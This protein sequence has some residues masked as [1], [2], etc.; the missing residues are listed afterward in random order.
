MFNNMFA[1]VCKVKIGAKLE[2]D[3]HD[4]EQPTIGVSQHNYLSP[5]KS[6][7]YPRYYLEIFI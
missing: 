6:R 7:Q 4:Q 1:S 2:Y 3:D 5:S